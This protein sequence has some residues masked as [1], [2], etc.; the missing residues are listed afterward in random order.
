MKHFQVT[1]LG[2]LVSS[3]ACK[4]FGTVYCLFLAPQHILS[5]GSNLNPFCEIYK[6]C[7][8]GH[9]QPQS[10]HFLCTLCGMVNYWHVGSYAHLLRVSCMH[11]LKVV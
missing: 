7:S 1:S 5:G 6:C 10:A 3:L 9:G 11:L 8:T 2:T 4:I